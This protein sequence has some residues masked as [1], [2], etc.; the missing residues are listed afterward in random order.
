MIDKYE[1]DLYKDLLYQS[2]VQKFLIRSELWPQEE[3]VIPEENYYLTKPF[4]EEEVKNALFP[5]EKI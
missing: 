5:I 1:L 4:S 3:N 2:M